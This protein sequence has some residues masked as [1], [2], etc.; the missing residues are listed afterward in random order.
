MKMGE[1]PTTVSFDKIEA[2]LGTEYP[3]GCQCEHCQR[4]LRRRF[5]KSGGMLQ[6]VSAALDL[7]PIEVVQSVYSAFDQS[8]GIRI[9]ASF[10]ASRNPCI[11]QALNIVFAMRNH[12]T[13]MSRASSPGVGQLTSDYEYISDYGSHLPASKRSEYSQLLGILVQ[14]WDG[15]YRSQVRILMG[16]YLERKERIGRIPE[17]VVPE[18]FILERPSETTM[19]YDISSP[20]VTIT[21]RNDAPPPFRN[22]FKRRSVSLIPRG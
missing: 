1:I 10:E 11:V 14:L 20:P 21:A 22:V 5:N 2:F 18:T 15:G 7:Y 13:P 17:T 12:V 19:L 8:G 9:I 4:N 6:E 3:T 16:E